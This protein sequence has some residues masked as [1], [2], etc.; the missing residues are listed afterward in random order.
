[1]KTLVSIVV[2]IFSYENTVGENEHVVLERPISSRLSG[3]QGSGR[4]FGDMQG[5]VVG[6]DQLQ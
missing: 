4:V 6:L 2:Y 5:D 1:M 3:G